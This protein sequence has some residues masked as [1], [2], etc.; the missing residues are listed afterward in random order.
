MPHTLTSLIQTIVSRQDLH[1]RWLNTFS[2]LEYIG[3]RKIVKSQEADGLSAETLSHA[4]EEG[5]HA[6]RLRKAS[7]RLGGADNYKDES[8]L[9]RKEAEDYFQEL[10]RSCAACLELDFPGAKGR[11]LTYVY[12]TWL[13]EVRALSVYGVYQNFLP[14][15]EVGLKGLLAEEEKHL[16]SVEEE[17]Q[18]DPDFSHRVRKLQ[19]VEER[20]YQSYL[21][22]LEREV[23]PAGAQHVAHP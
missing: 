16:R 11:R 8:L 19:E 22:A 18:G 5:R 1:A 3:F 4:V 10:D 9:C 21:S 2:Y 12:V 15:D 14:G 13:V 6:L 17:L 23:L 7:L 20:L